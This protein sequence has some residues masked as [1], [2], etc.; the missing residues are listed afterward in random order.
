MQI[1]PTIITPDYFS[2]PQP[3]ID[4]RVSI[5]SAYRYLEVGTAD[6]Y[7]IQQADYNLDPN[8]VGILS[9]L[10]VDKKEDMKTMSAI[11]A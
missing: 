6:H 4:P 1:R 8:L 10:R 5:I 7:L 9:Q 11:Y 2:Q 3:R